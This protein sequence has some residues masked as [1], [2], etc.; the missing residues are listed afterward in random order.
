M[1]K[2]IDVSVPLREGMVVWP[3]STGFRLRQTMCLERGDTA[4]VSQLDCDVHIG[5]HVDAPRHFL[6]DGATVEQLPMDILIGP[7]V[8]AYLPEVHTIT[9]SVLNDLVLPAGTKRLLLRTSNSELWAAAGVSEFREDFVALTDDAA[10]W[11]V[12]HDIR[13]IGV[14]YLSVQ[15]YEDNPGVHQILLGQGV[16]IIEGL[17]LSNVLPGSYELICLPLKLVGAEGAPARA[18]LRP[19]NKEAK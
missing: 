2:I 4:N 12:T 6:K 14:D 16:I 13:L 3:G 1:T 10:Q 8:L 15:R 17:N 18:V 19:L 7:A 5:T 9:V 11:V